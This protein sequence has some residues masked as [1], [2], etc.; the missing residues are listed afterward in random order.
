MIIM[1]RYAL[2]SVSCTI[3]NLPNKTI[4]KN[5]HKRKFAIEIII[6]FLG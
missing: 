4:S 6:I 5:N 1:R 3:E 2:S